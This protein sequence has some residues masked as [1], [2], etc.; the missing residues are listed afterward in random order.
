[1]EKS[2]R[3]VYISIKVEK[4][5]FEILIL[6]FEHRTWKGLQVKVKQVTDILSHV[7]T[8]YILIESLNH[9]EFDLILQREWELF[10]FWFVYKF[11][12]RC[13]HPFL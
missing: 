8:I 3:E 7:I 9:I 13:G 11:F 10:V 4:V 1:M 12:C 6:I 2:V 5:R